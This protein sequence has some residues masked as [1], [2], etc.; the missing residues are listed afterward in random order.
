M[1]LYLPFLQMR[2]AA[3]EP[4]VGPPSR[5][6]AV[7]AD[8][9]RAP[10]AFAFAFVVTLLFALPLYLLKIEMVPRE[11]AWLPSLVFI[12]FIF[13]ARLLT[14]WALG[15]AARRPDAAALVLPLDRPA[16]AAARG[17]VLRADRLL[18]A[19]HELE[20]RLEPVRAAR[21]PR[22]GAVL[23]HVMLGPSRSI[24]PRRSISRQ[25]IVCPALSLCDAC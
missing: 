13:P 7:R 3:D 16:A 1:L 5:L 2:L 4:A 19:V 6:R 24:V 18:H 10:W 14:G 12:A 23:R 8:F 15:R 9:G 17:G 22:A 11:A 25:K 20:R 21:L